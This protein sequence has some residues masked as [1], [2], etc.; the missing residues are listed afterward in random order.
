[1][2]P[3]SITIALAI[4]ICSLPAQTQEVEL[5]PKFGN[6]FTACHIDP[7]DDRKTCHA[8]NGE[9]TVTVTGKDHWAIFIGKDHYP[10]SHVYLRLDKQKARQSES[11][12]WRGHDAGPILYDFRT[13]GHATLRYTLF[14]GRQVIT[15]EINMAGA[16]EMLDYLIQNIAKK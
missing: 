4:S 7:I 5:G 12:G 1:M 8:G 10:G 11:P 16:G 14:I 9:I 6:W 3:I 15:K 2:K 13:A